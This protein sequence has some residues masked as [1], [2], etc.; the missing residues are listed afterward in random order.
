MGCEGA[1]EVKAKAKCDSSF[2]RVIQ[3][4]VVRFDGGLGLGDEGER[5]IRKR[6]GSQ[7]D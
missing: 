4:F 7:S 3:D 2:C 1:E 6:K 5:E